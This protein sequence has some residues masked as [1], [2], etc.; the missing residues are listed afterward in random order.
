VTALCDR[1]PVTRCAT[2]RQDALIGWVPELLCP[3][4]SQRAAGRFLPAELL[5]H[6]AAQLLPLL[7]LP[8]ERVRGLDTALL[9][10][11]TSTMRGTVF[12]TEALV[13]C[14]L[15][16]LHLTL[17]L[18]FQVMIFLTEALVSSQVNPCLT[19][20]ERPCC[21]MRCGLSGHSA[22]ARRAPAASS[23]RTTAPKGAGRSCRRARAWCPLSWRRCASWSS[24]VRAPCYPG[25]QHACAGELRCCC[26]ADMSESL[27]TPMTAW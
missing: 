14:P 12:L 4:A 10:G 3:V 19:S 1:P 21:A 11:H 27:R 15:S 25:A 26:D 22:P 6:A 9:N 24:S 13:S 17:T 18:P 5:P 2:S 16:S 7:L 8:P 20:T 23:R